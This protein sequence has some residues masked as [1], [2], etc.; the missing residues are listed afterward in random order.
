MA[1]YDLMPMIDFVLESTGRESLSFIGYS[2]GTAQ[3]FA[4]LAN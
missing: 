4:A 1:N 2:H 3:M